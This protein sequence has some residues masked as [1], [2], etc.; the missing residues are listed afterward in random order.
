[1]ATSA[2]NDLTKASESTSP[3]V[4]YSPLLFDPQDYKLIQMVNNTVAAR[5]HNN[6]LTPPESDLHPNGII[7]MTSEHGLRLAAAVIVLLESLEAGDA[8][9]RIR[10][11][12][13]LH[14]EVLYS[15]HSSLRNNTA[16]VLVQIMK[17]LVRSYD[18][19]ARQIPLAHEFHSAV[20]G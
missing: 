16:R 10:A 17:D 19:H 12:R 5:A 18:D 13:R 6:A 20:R 7:E 14:D 11:L 8:N 3:Q 15:T 4:H 9:E 1:M 2:Q